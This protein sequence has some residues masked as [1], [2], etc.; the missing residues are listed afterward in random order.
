MKHTKFFSHRMASP[1]GKTIAQVQSIV[2]VSGDDQAKTSQS[3]TVQISHDRSSNSSSSSI[4][5]SAS[6]SVSSS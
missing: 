3:I 6:V 1:D 5:G 2:T 4:S